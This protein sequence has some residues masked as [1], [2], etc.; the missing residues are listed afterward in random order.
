MP[1]AFTLAA[2][3]WWMHAM[4]RHVAFSD[5]PA[6]PGRPLP[7]VGDIV[8]AARA[9]GT[10]LT[11]W[12]QSPELEFPACSPDGCVRWRD[13]GEVSLQTDDQFGPGIA[14][15]GFRKPSPSAVLDLICALTLTAGPMLIIDEC[16]CHGVP[17]GPGDE[18]AAVS[19]RPEW[20]W[21]YPT[22]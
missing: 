4:P 2:V 19:R 13:L 7:T 21:G 6:V 11:L 18:P 16:V 10:H 5:D 14:F 15:A 8:A 3:S 9:S 17:I 1:P 22:A 12:D 20:T